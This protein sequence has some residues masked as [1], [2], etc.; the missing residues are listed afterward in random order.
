M[1]VVVN[2]PVEPQGHGAFVRCIAGFLASKNSLF[3]TDPRIEA[4]RDA[5]PGANCGAVDIPAVMVL[6]QPWLQVWSLRLTGVLQE[7]R[8]LQITWA[9]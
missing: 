9:L 6:L 5:L 1:K 7:E 2:V 4:I 8:L 3:E